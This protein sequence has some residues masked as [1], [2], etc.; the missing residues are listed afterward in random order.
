MNKI[1]IFGK[2]FNVIQK[3][4]K[5]DLIEKKDVT[6]LIEYHQRDAKRLWAKLFEKN[7]I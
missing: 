1:T 7:I 4:S 3:E 5:R 6:L 2:D